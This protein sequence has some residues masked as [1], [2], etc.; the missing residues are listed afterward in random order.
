M[1]RK[2]ALA[3][4]RAARRVAKAFQEVERLTQEMAT[5]VQSPDPSAR[6]TAER[7]LVRQ[8]GL[9]ER[10]VPLLKLYSSP[11]DG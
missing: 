7:C 3:I 11:H 9:L 10:V 5:L 1:T 2:Q 4:T 6:A 8:H